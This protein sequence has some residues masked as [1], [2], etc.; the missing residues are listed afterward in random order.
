MKKKQKTL[1]KINYLYFLFAFVL[2]AT[3]FTYNITMLKSPFNEGKWFFLIYSA[4]EITIEA[5]ILL[6]IFSLLK[7]K[8]LLSAFKALFFI[9]FFVHFVDS[10]V[11]AFLDI[12]VWDGLNI[13][14]NESMENLLEMLTYANIPIYGWALMAFSMLF[15]PIVGIVIYN[16]F[17]RLSNKRP[18]CVTK[19]KLCFSISAFVFLA[20]VF[21]LSF[22]GI[23][24]YETHE[25][26]KKSLP[27]KS[28]ILPKKE[29]FFPVSLNLK[30]LNNEAQ[31]ELKEK[32][33]IFLFIADS[34]RE[35]YIDE[36]IA[37]C[38]SAFKK[39]NLFF[40]N[41]FSNSNA[42]PTSWLAIFFSR[43]PFIWSYLKENPWQNGSPPLAFLKKGGYKINLFSS[44]ELDYY[45]MADL[46]FAKD[47]KLIDNYNFFSHHLPKRACH[48]D[49]HAIQS[50]IAS[51]KEKEGNIYVIFLDSTHYEYSYPSN[52][53]LKFQPSGEETSLFMIESG[54][55]KMKNRYRNSIAFIDTLFQKFL[56]ALKEKGLY[57]NSIIIFTSDHGQEFFE[58]GHIFHLSH[59]SNMQ[60]R[61]PIYCKFKDNSAF[62]EKAK[63]ISHV[64]IFPTILH[65]LTGNNAFPFL[66]GRSFLQPLPEQ[67]AITARYNGNLSPCEFFISDGSEKMILRLNDPNKIVRNTKLKIVGLKN[68]KDEN[69]FITEE[70]IRKFINL[71]NK[72]PIAKN[73][74]QTP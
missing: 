69:L 24:N 18:L 44:A 74:S 23:L 58:E 21:D 2:V 57:D 9:F 26:F 47:H 6:L 65:F 7:N 28:E 27:W 34:I 67:M 12:S 46:L 8:T 63:V 10:L 59:L 3:S 16:F 11:I 31:I 17:D 43:L 30:P 71:L 72:S 38:L 70:K 4:I 5:S 51:L 53:P 52:F 64:D 37:P 22:S 41:S 54:L 15:I 13:L 73:L 56:I 55:E 48:S 60:T 49:L 32:P 50:L 20:L 40:E 42:T 61:V 29:C 45:K 33:N 25:I 14:K 66:D 68:E 19:A 36:N 35:D 39:E 1:F 62:Q